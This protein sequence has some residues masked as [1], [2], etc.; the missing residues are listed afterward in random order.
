MFMRNDWKPIS[1]RIFLVRFN[2]S[3]SFNANV[4]KEKL[5]T[6]ILSC[7]GLGVRNKRE[8]RLSSCAKKIS[9]LLLI[10]VFSNINEDYTWISPRRS[11]RNQIDYSLIDS[12]C[13][14]VDR[15]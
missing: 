5:P 13:R 6:E 4:G 11:Y 1:D 8:N 7:Y 14:G 2:R 10:P 15:L 9:L 12:R 3:R